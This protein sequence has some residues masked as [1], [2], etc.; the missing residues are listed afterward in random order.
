[1]CVCYLDQIF[2]F[3]GSWTRND[4]L[5]SGHGSSLNSS[6]KAAAKEIKLLRHHSQNQIM[7]HGSKRKK[8]K[9]EL[10]YLA[11]VQQS[12]WAE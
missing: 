3:H 11:H 12:S 5:R 1:M 6:W 4:A 9:E 8:K 7:R 2:I 10:P